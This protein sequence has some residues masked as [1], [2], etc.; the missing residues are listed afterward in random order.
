MGIAKGRQ[1]VVGAK[2]KTPMKSHD[3]INDKNSKIDS[4]R[5][6]EHA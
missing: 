2:F 5:S 1:N 3:C 4:K 6:T